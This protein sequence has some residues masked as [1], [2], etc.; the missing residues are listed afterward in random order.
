MAVTPVAEPI[1]VPEPLAC[2]IYSL[3]VEILPVL[4]VGREVAQ[5]VLGLRLASAVYPV[6]A[7]SVR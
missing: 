5:T 3:A 6:L 2:T 1:V 7:N 4:V